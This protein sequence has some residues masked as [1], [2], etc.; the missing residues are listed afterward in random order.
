[1]NISRWVQTPDVVSYFTRTLDEKFNAL[2]RFNDPKG[3]YTHCLCEL[4]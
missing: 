1:M 2:F 4:N 3:M